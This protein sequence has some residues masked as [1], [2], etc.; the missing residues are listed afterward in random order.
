MTRLRGALFAAITSSVIG[1]GCAD[2]PPPPSD[3]PVTLPEDALS[4]QPELGLTE[5]RVSVIAPVASTVQL[6]PPAFSA[7]AAVGTSPAQAQSVSE[8][9]EVI[10]EVDVV[11]QPR[12]Q[13]LSVEIISP[14][15]M[16]YEAREIEVGGDP[17]A[18]YRAQFILPVAGTAI[19]RSNL[20]GTWTANYFLG[21]RPVATTTFEL[22]P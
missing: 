22:L 5:P 7:T 16:P 1:A 21:G 2:K 12:S 11:G 6:G 18:T 13:P 10:L 15:A 17:F 14:N 3:R 9:R 19:D 4:D 8:V 20:S